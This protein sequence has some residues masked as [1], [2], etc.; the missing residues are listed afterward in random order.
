MNH[1][2]YCSQIPFNI[3]NENFSTK[4]LDAYNRNPK[5]YTPIK[6]PNFVENYV[7]WSFKISVFPL[8]KKYHTG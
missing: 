6:I 5:K 7:I 3:K 4:W 1:N 2:F 8:D